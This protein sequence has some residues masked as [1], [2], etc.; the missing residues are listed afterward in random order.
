[1]LIHIAHNATQAKLANNPPREIK[2]FVNTLLSYEV[3]GAMGWTGRS[4]FFSVTTDSFPAGFVH[5]VKEELS[6]AG[7]VVQIVR[8]PHAAPLGPENPVVDSFGNEDPRYDYQ[9]RSLRQV[10]KYGAGI[11]RVA[12]GGGKSKIAKLIMRRYARTTL[13]LTTR[14]ILLYQM[15]DQVEEM[16]LDTGII[17]DGE[18]KFSKE[19][20][21]GMVQTFVAALKE[22]SLDAEIRALVKSIHGAKDQSRVTMSPEEVRRQATAIYEAKVKKRDLIVRFLEMVEV[23]IGEEAHEAGG[24]SYYEILRHCK[25]ATIR[26]ALT[27]TPFMRDS[28]GDNMR[29][30]AAFGPVLIDV[31]EEMLIERGIL[32]KPYFKFANVSPPPKLL[33]STAFDRAYVLGYTENPNMH[34]A[35]IQDAL[36]AR[37]H[38]LPVLALV[39]RVQHGSNLAAAMK[40]NGLRVAF[41]KGEDDMKARRAELENLRLGALDV[42]IGTNILDVGVDVPAI[43]LIQLAAG[44]KAQVSLRQRIGRGLRAKKAGPNVAFIVDYSCNTNNHLYEHAKQR[45]AIVRSIKGFVEGVVNKE[46][47]LPWSIFTR[48]AA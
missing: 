1:M 28:Q 26:V 39:A 42:V 29:L 23:V 2:G 38:G 34:R 15:K 8:K 48:K 24:D 43:G 13:F 21:F 46:A 16:G 6:R 41:I 30:M 32:A 19:I 33:K 5:L 47:D 12:T 11:I 9:M 35:I 44:M 7:H 14:G 37:Q 10:E 45:E 25:N 17:G 20:N 4:S 3:T 18:K 31:S 27:A 36:K 22:T 40:A